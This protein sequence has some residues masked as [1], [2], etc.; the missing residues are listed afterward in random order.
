MVR[1][2]NKYNQEWDS[3]NS[4]KAYCLLLHGLIWNSQITKGNQISTCKTTVNTTD[5]NEEELLKVSKRNKSPIRS[6]KMN[7]YSCRQIT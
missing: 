1:A 3:K 4:Y 7:Y 5:L 6:T 2:I